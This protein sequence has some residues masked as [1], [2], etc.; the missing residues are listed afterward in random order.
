MARIKV[1]DIP[2]DQKISK[3]ELKRIRGGAAYIKIDVFSP[4]QTT[5]VYPK[6]ESTRLD[7]TFA[8]KH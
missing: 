7:P 1:K 3:D 5:S 2:K 6:I 4:I 8:D